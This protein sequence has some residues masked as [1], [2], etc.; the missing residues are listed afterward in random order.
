M[1]GRYSIFDFTT[2]FVAAILHEAFR[3]SCWRWRTCPHW[4]LNHGYGRFDVVAFFNG[5]DVVFCL[6]S[7]FHKFQLLTLKPNK[8]LHSMPDTPVT[9]AG[10]AGIMGGV[11]VMRELCVSRTR[12]IPIRGVLGCKFS[13]LAAVLDYLTLLP[14]TEPSPRL[15]ADVVWI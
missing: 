11:S 14:R 5:H 2:K 12:L 4:R 15:H 7:Y 8:T 3:V 10:N 9:A 6:E 1:D 13:G